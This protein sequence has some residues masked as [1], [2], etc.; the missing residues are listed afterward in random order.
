[1]PNLNEQIKELRARTGAGVVDCQQALKAAQGDLELAIT[2][3]RQKGKAAVAKKATR[4]T[5]EGIITTYIHGNHKLGVMVSLLCETDFVARNDRFHELARNI[6]LH[7]AAADPAV[8]RPE[9]LPEEIVAS[10]RAIAQEQAK[11]SGKPAAIQEKIVSGKLDSF[12][13]E[14]ALLTQPFVKD[15]NKTVGE[16]IQEAV[17]ELGENISVGSFSRLTV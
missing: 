7:I 5:N 11:S 12:R 14:K 16:L 8:V 2:W 6:A 10:E 17:L 13:Q 15:L 1:M 9:D 4:R 3:L